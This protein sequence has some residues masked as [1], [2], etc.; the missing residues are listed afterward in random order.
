MQE[1]EVPN[2]IVVEPSFPQLGD[3][4]RIE[5]FVLEHPQNFIRLEDVA[6]EDVAF[7]NELNYLGLI[8]RTQNVT[9]GL[10]LVDG[11]VGLDSNRGLQ[12]GLTDDGATAA[13]ITRVDGEI[14]LSGGIEEALK[15]NRGESV[16]RD[17]GDLGVF[18]AL[19]RNGSFGNIQ[20][21][22]KFQ[23]SS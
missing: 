21:H 14:T 15:G 9:E 17:I 3:D 16:D 8:T 23:S 7:L 13:G 4:L 2:L 5:I 11:E 20:K 18:V 22:L 6:V 1:P 12:S 10:E 19:Q